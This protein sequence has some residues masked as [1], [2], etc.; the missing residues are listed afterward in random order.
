MQYIDH[1]ICIHNSVFANAQMNS[2]NR[3]LPLA[4]AHVLLQYQQVQQLGVLATACITQYYQLKINMYKQRKV[5]TFSTNKA[6]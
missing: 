2:R 3:K 1:I 4:L 5:K 6:Q